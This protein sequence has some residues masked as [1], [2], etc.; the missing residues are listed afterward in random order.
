MSRLSAVLFEGL[1]SRE[2][3]LPD[4]LPVVASSKQSVLERQEAQ[5]NHLRIGP[6]SGAH[7][8]PAGTRHKM[9][10]GIWGSSRILAKNYGSELD[11][12]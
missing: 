5:G 10:L 7:R 3:T 6:V 2:V 12:M 11:D 8:I 4:L 9:R 1:G